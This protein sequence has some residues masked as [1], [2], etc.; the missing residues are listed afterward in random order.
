MRGQPIVFLC[1]DI[2]SSFVIH[3]GAWRGVVGMSALFVV[4]AGGCSAGA[5]QNAGM[6]ASAAEATPSSEQ[7]RGGR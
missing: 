4:E 2:E 5:E 3:P 7:G 1:S 6:C